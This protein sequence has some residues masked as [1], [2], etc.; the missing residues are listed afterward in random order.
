MDFAVSAHYINQTTVDIVRICYNFQNFEMMS[1][2]IYCLLYSP[3]NVT[4]RTA[5]KPVGFVLNK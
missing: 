2:K 5:F 4:Y 3:S 1:T